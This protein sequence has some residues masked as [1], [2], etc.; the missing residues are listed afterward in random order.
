V[1]TDRLAL[2][3]DRCA[4]VYRDWLVGEKV[5]ANLMTDRAALLAKVRHRIS[6]LPCPLYMV[7]E[8]TQML[9][10]MLSQDLI[11]RIANEAVEAILDSDRKNEL[12]WPPRI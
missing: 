7:T 12:T 3:A 9:G 2:L 6:N 1:A 4:S 8:R 10:E 5:D 11:D